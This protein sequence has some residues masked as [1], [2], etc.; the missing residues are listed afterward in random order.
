MSVL[1]ALIWPFTRWLTETGYEEELC[2]AALSSLYTI[3]SHERALEKFSK[4]MH[5]DDKEERVG[6]VICK[7]LLN[8]VAP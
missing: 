6:G 2:L 5:M 3:C 1:C 8:C 7:N 4:G